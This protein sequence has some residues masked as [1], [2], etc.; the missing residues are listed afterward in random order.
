MKHFIKWKIEEALSVDDGDPHKNRMWVTRPAKSND[1]IAVA[2]IVII[3]LKEGNEFV[4]WQVWLGDAG[5][6]TLENR[7]TITL[8][9]FFLQILTV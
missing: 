8:L 9:H 3:K 7:A 5:S 1:P 2:K 6:S 4:P